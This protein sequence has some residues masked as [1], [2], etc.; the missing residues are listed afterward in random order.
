MEVQLL[1][2]DDRLIHGQVVTGWVGFLKSTKLILCDNEISDNEWEKELYLSCVPPSLHANIFNV[3]ETVSYL[4]DNTNSQERV[5]VLVKSPFTISAL[6]AEGYPVHEV[7]VGG[8]H[9]EDSRKQYLSYIFINDTEKAEFLKLM[10][11]GVHFI[12]QDVPGGKKVE[13]KDLLTK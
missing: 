5:I 11:K 9:F 4:Q 8:L 3:K 13:L 7:N 12:C 10:E 1:R 2:I 6:I